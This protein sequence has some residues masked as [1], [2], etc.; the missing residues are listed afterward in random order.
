MLTLTL[1]IGISQAM[2]FI[3]IY[4]KWKELMHA[5]EQMSSLTI[6]KKLMDYSYVDLDNF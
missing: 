5:L 4:N 6:M 3:N 2:R 1:S